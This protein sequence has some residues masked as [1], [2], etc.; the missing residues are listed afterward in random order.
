MIEA[1]FVLCRRALE[2]IEE[3]LVDLLDL[4]PD[5]LDRH[6][7]RGVPVGL[8]MRT[9]SLLSVGLLHVGRSGGLQSRRL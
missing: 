6:C 4:D 5:V 3:G 1:G 7:Q 2:L 8:P 9:G